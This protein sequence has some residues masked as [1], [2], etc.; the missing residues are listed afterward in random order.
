MLVFLVKYGGN[1]NSGM[2]IASNIGNLIYSY[3][4]VRMVIVIGTLLPTLL[5]SF[6]NNTTI[7]N[8][9]CINYCNLITPR[10]RK[11]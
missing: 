5:I 8:T 10:A 1:A 11:P 9:V 2:N 7:T 3:M 6:A 4:L